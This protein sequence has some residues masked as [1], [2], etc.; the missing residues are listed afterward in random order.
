MPKSNI[1][2]TLSNDIVL[3]INFG[4]RY[5][6]SIVTVISCLCTAEFFVIR[7][8]D[9][10]NFKYERYDYENTILNLNS[11]IQFQGNKIKELEDSIEKL[12][13]NAEKREKKIEELEKEIT[14]RRDRIIIL[15]Q[16]LNLYNWKSK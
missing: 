15:E 12:E 16:Q 11:N 10:Y 1:S 9:E 2:N 7:I 3:A 4:I 14:E 8:I 5:W 6:K 13:K